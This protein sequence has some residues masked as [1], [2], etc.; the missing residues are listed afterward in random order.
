MGQKR[1]DDAYAQY[2][3][4]LEKRPAA[5]IYT[6][7]GI[8]EDSR[9]K[10]A[11]AEKAYRQALTIAPETT[12]A[13]NNLAWLLADNQGNLDEALQ[14]ATLAVSKNQAVAGYYDTL[15]WVYLKKGLA[16]S[17]VEQFKK[18]VILEDR[19]AQTNGVAPDP[20]YR[21]RLGMALAKT[22][23]KTARREVKSSLR[24]INVIS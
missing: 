7:L 15:G 8:L 12:I 20:G 22:G 5:Q 9:G 18:A 1:P 2:K 16:S 24:G 21:E 14:L 13:A 10:T 23:D 11:E 6:M 19:N 3:R 17:A 4:A